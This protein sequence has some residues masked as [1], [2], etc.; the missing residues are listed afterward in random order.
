MSPSELHGSKVE[1]G[2]SDFIDEAYQNF[3]IMGVPLEEK[4]KLLAYEHKRVAKI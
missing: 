3:T 2:P 4:A 1:N